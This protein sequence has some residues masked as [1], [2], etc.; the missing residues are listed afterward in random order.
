MESRKLAASNEALLLEMDFV[1]SRVPLSRTKHRPSAL[2]L[3]VALIGYIALPARAALTPGLE[4][5]L[6]RARL[7]AGAVAVYAMDA[8]TGIEVVSHNAD[9]LFHPAS[10]MK[11]ITTLVSLEMLGP[12]HRWETVVLSRGRIAKGELQGDLSFKGVGD[13]TL[14]Q[15]KLSILAKKLVRRGIR[16]IKGD[17]ILDKSYFD[18]PLPVS[19]QFFQEMDNP[20]NVWPEP[21]LVDAKMVRLAVFP[22]LKQRAIAYKLE[23]D[24]PAVS[25][26]NLVEVGAGA[27]NGADSVLNVSVEGAAASAQINL[28]GKLSLQCPTRSRKISVLSPD[29]YFSAALRK[30]FEQ[31]GGRVEGKILGGVTSSQ[32]RPIEIIQ[33]E[34]LLDVVRQ[35]NKHSNNLM[36]RLLLLRLG[37]ESTKKPAHPGRSLNVLNEWLR[38]RF[39]ASPPF[40]MENGSGLSDIERATARGLVEF[41]QYA[42]LSPRGAQFFDSLPVVG[43]DGTMQ[44]HLRNHPVAG[45]AFVKTGTLRDSKAMAGL[46]K[47]RHGRN[48]LFAFIANHGRADD[49]VPA[50]ENLIAWLYDLRR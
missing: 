37:A 28:T 17:V 44:N 10:V 48:Y 30:S 40:V 36:A 42:R 2:L 27:C 19:E 13:P 45:K 33:S 29:G 47:N 21:L 8:D 23:P 35:I 4:R 11:V 38:E 14:D 5:D 41:F 15:S 25:V 7:P 18:F 12:N 9:Q 1:S 34:P 43:R 20:L 6:A 3:M 50:M 31:A 24:F 16:A 26:K 22:D 46:V 39:G 49:A 32:A